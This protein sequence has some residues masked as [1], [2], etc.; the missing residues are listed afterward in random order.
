MPSSNFRGVIFLT[1]NCT[2]WY[3]S[4]RLCEKCRSVCDFEVLLLLIQSCKITRPLFCFV[5]TVI[6]Y[7]LFGILL[8]L[9]HYLTLIIKSAIR[10]FNSWLLIQQR[11]QNKGT[12]FLFI[13]HHQAL[14]TLPTSYTLNS[15]GK[16]HKV[17]GM[18]REVDD[19]QS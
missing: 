4:S 5:L 1:K 7:P 19:L 12:H 15:T 10:V 16:A 17:G 2:I 3:L 8:R 14:I 9:N 18:K 6:N 13:L 11:Y